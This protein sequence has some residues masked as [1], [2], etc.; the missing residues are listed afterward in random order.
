MRGMRE[1]RW[2]AS[3]WITGAVM[4]LAYVAASLL[5]PEMDRRWRLLIALGAG[6]A[7][8]LVC[9]LLGRKKTEKI[10]PGEADEDDILPPLR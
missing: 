5:A 4:L 2:G 1:T 3:N 9:A 10:R 8:G 6:L 7:A